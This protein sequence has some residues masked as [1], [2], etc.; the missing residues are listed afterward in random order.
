MLKKILKVTAFVLVA[1][2]TLLALFY[3]EEN[4]RGKAAWERHLRELEAKGDTLDI[5]KVAPPLIPDAQNMAA[6]PIFA[7]LMTASNQDQTRLA[8][9]LKK[10]LPKAMLAAD[11]RLGQRLDKAKLS[12]AFSNE[13]ILAALQ[14][15]VGVLK[16]VAEAAERP[17][18]RFPIQYEKGFAC[19][20]PHLSS[21]RNVARTLKF[22]ALA[23]LDAG[24]TEAA[25]K[26]V[27]LMLRLANAEE[28]EPMLISLLVRIACTSLALQT[29]W[30][31][32]ADH[33]WND[34]QLRLLQEDIS[35]AN[36]L[37]H[38]E[39]AFHAERCMA[40]WTL[41]LLIADPGMLKQMTGAES[42]QGLGLLP[43]GWIYIN[44]L[45][46]EL[47][48]QQHILPCVDSH[49]GRI[50][51]ER[52]AACEAA[53]SKTTH[54]QCIP[55]HVL[56]GLLV[57]AVSSVITKTGVAQ[58][59]IQSAA[60]AC[61]LERYY[62]ANGRYPDKLA[63]LVPQFITTVP[64]DVIDGQ[65]LR[66]RRDGTGFVIYSVGWN[67]TDDGGQIVLQKN[68]DPKAQSHIDDKLG[69]WVWRSQPAF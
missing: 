57:P 65:P 49:A 38:L 40:R 53:I 27:R 42:P 25:L 45:N 68:A 33:R 26:D 6:A 7:E 47:C 20:L 43:S 69:D 52:A 19:L 62:L 48:Y 67:Q 1:L 10:V 51:P 18:C 31:G 58:T 24:Q 3:V 63:A 15:A 14:P 64:R 12:A 2:I 61:A 54:L 23:E 22:R 55:Y 8:A 46:V 35:Q 41:N 9:T 21:W 29:V 17:Q 37:S 56:E 59:S 30:E 4:V 16:E 28:N 11:W 50:Y 34:K 32:L 36:M 13:N 60:L 66:Y 5:L 44:C 39:T